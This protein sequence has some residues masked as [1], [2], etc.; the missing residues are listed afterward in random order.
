[1]KTI[2]LFILISLVIISCEKKDTQ[3]AC[4]SDNP[5]E[6]VTWLK[7]MKDSL[8]N[9][10]CEISIIQGTY[11]NQTV[12]FVAMTDP[13]CDGID[14]PTLLDCYGNVVRQFTQEDYQEFYTD[15]TRDIVLYRCK[16]TKF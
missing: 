4:R 3:N 12:F 5:I 11:K 9:C 8:T 6:E 7:E 10:Y 16:M 13:L 15:V 14:I 2:F 1:M